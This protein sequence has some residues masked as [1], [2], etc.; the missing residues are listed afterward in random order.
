MPVALPVG[1]YQEGTVANPIADYLFL[2]AL[3]VPTAGILAGVLYLLAPSRGLSRNHT[4]A[5]EAKAH[6]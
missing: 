6:G 2:A 1:N 4:H 3:F 5:G